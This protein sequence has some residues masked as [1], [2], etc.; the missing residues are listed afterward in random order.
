[1]KNYTQL[2]AQAIRAADD[3]VE[4]HGLPSYSYLIKHWVE[5][6]L[7]MYAVL[8]DGH[9][10]I[11]DQTM[12][13][14]TDTLDI[15]YWKNYFE[16]RFELELHEGNIPDGCEDYSITITEDPEG[17]SCWSSANFMLEAA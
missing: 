3:A 2:Q 11:I 5:E 10:D 7:P 4:L 13:S 15:E 9:G 12:L 1:M 17:V 16:H 14:P 6:P 8:K